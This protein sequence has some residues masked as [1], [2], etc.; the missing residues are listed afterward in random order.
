MYSS[1]I[2]DLQSPCSVDLS[3]LTV[4]VSMA[5]RLRSIE[6]EDIGGTRGDID[7]N[8]DDIAGLFD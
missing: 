1:E 2:K 3:G 7:A 5:F 4:F 6:S 8:V